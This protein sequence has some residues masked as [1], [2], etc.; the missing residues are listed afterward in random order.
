M[1][2]KLYFLLALLPLWHVAAAD[3]A[4]TVGATRL[5]YNGASNEANLN[6]SNR[7]DTSPYL[8]QSWVSRFGGTSEESVDSFSRAWCHSRAELY[9]VSWFPRNEQVGC[10]KSRRAIS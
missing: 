4:V 8:V 1:R 10:T 3:A 9:Y 2:L 7:E 6:V 5:I